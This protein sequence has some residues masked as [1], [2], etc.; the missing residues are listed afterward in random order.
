MLTAYVYA[1]SQQAHV[2]WAHKMCVELTHIFCVLY[3]AAF[4]WAYHTPVFTVFVCTIIMVHKLITDRLEHNLDI[5]YYKPCQLWCSLNSLLLL[6]ELALDSI[7]CQQFDVENH[8]D[9]KREIRSEVYTYSQ[10]SLTH[11]NNTSSLIFEQ[12]YH[13]IMLVLLKINICSDSKPCL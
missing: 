2:H 9:Y 6:L 3:V 12:V 5:I 10:T 4:L 13:T 1:C 11:H 7:L 8:T